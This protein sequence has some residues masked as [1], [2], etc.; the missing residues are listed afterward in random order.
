MHKCPEQTL[1]GVEVVREAKLA[2]PRTQGAVGLPTFMAMYGRVEALFAGIGV[3]FIF[4]RYG[5]S[6]MSVLGP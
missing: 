4:P 2:S 1:S 6:I 5:R 3:V